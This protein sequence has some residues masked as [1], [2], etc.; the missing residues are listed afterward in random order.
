MA[1]E[2]QVRRQPLLN[3]VLRFTR[4]PRPE[5][6]VGGGK[7][8]SNIKHERLDQQRSRLAEN[9][10]QMA[11]ECAS[12]PQ[13][14]GRA[15][16]YAQMFADSLAATWTPN[17]LLHPERGARL[18][19]PYRQGYLAEIDVR[20][21]DWFSHFAITASNARDRVDIS[22]VE[23]VRFH[24][25]DD[26]IRGRDLDAMWQ[27]APK[28]GEGRS[29][30]I[31][32]MPVSDGRAAEA[33]LKTLVHLRETQIE[34]PPP[35]LDGVELDTVP[36]DSFGRELVAIG[37][38]D[39]LNGALRQYRRERQASTVVVA[40]SR[41]A[42]EALLA[43]GTVVR[44]EPVLPLLTTSP[45]E[46][47]EPARPLPDSLTNLPIVG[48]VDGGM[49]APSYRPAEAWRADPPL[50]SNAAAEVKHGN[51]V[52]SLVVQGHDWNNNLKLP[53]LY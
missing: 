38:G 44:L 49:T 43:S 52:T 29:F 27:E 41:A 15:I 25:R 11:R 31:W 21:L 20:R 7:S 33:V 26:V 45:G 50:V 12:Q 16:V 42:F 1:D 9:F 23:S 4:N 32:F 14:D 8:A 35:L 39:R 2:V 51:R 53:P 10:S 47:A 34:T 48:I 6:V 17:D 30:L 13:F 19:T 46:G 3:P 28:F 22:R 18:I 40:R 37:E 5:S 36:A 24:G